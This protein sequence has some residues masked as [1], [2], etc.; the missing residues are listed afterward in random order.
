MSN[1]PVIFWFRRD[2]RLQDNL[3]FK[4]ALDS[5][6]PVIPLFIFDP[7]ILQSPRIGAPRLKFMLNA[8]ESLSIEL[9]KHQRELLIR[10][11]DPNDVLRALIDETGADKLFFNIDYTPFARKRDEI[12]QNT[13]KIDVQAFHDRLLAAP[14]DVLKDDGKPYVVY[15]PFKN[16]WRKLPKPDRPERY[17]I[18]ADNLHTLEGIQN[19]G[20]PTIADLGFDETINVPIASE[21]KALHILEAYMSKP[22]YSYKEGRNALGNP[23]TAQPTNPLTQ[24]SFL[25][26]YIRFGL[27][28]LRQIYWSA[29]DAHAETQSDDR[30]E[31]VS[32]FVNEIIWHEFY[33]HIL[34]FFPQVKTANFYDKYDD[35]AWNTSDSDLQAW[36]DGQTG[37]P[38]VDAAMRQLKAT[39]WMHNRARMIVASFLTKDLLIDWR[40]GE[41]HFMQWLLDGDLAANN[42]GWQWAAGTGTDAQPYFRIFNPISQSTKFDPDGDF[43]RCWIPELRDVPDKFIH[44]P[45][46]MD[47]PPENYPPPIVDHS[48][49]RQRTLDAFK[50]AT[51]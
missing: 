25:S 13:L 8:L 46:K 6:Q 9:H 10:H 50:A 38:V 48:E 15:T 35:L 3:G 19:D 22:V 26:P 47:N 4:A 41:L 28:S 14:G 12:I 11:G 40:E 23:S 34:Y 20:I 31:S 21:D 1:P 7:A 27:V 30:Q 49:A 42:G 36:K 39:G 45:W 43:I 37:Y 17:E 29:R 33:T 16:K 24:T 44:E 32:T 51:K 18:S 5:E 2:L